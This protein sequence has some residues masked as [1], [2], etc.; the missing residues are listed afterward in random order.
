MCS[1]AANPLMKAAK[2]ANPAAEKSA[3]GQGQEKYQPH[4]HEGRSLYTPDKGTVGQV[5][6]KGRRTAS[7][8]ISY[9]KYID[10]TGTDHSVPD[11][12]VT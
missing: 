9:V 3:E 11:G 1:D 4:N 5:L 6:V 12:G 2:G 10:K 7:A 8:W